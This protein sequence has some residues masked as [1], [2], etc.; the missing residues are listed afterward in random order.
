VFDNIR[1]P[2]S[3]IYST[4]NRDDTPQKRSTGIYKFGNDTYPQGIRRRSNLGHIFWGKRCVLWSGKY[5][6]YYY[7]YYYYC[8]TTP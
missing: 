6:Y 4:H 2:Y 3:L 7:Y 1:R 5:Y 8:G